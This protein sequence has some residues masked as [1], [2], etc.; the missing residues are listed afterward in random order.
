MVRKILGT[1][2]WLGRIRTGITE[3][4]RHCTNHMSHR[5]TFLQIQRWVLPWLLFHQHRKVISDQAQVR[6]HSH[7][8]NNNNNN[9]NNNNKACLDN[10]VGEPEK[11]HLKP[12][13]RRKTI[14]LEIRFSWKKIS[15]FSWAKSGSDGDPSGLENKTLNHWTCLRADK[16]DHCPRSYISFPSC[17][18]LILTH[19]KLPFYPIRRSYTFL[20]ISLSSFATFL[21]LSL[22]PLTNFFLLSLSPITNFI[23]FSLFLLSLHFSF[24]FH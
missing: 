2:F 1:L 4:K 14:L 5:S 6:H 20:F 9:N 10:T 24:F 23:S 15:F 13:S 22:S 7:N 11:T 3:N 12:N 19:L 21:F 18:F 8:S 16:A 17:F